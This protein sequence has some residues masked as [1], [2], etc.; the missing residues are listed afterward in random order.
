MINSS[1]LDLLSFERRKDGTVH[2]LTTEALDTILSQPQ[3][4]NIERGETELVQSRLSKVDIIWAA[5]PENLS[6][7]IRVQTVWQ[8][9]S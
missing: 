6:V 3:A 5:T 2:I 1:C 9:E 8:S 7:L 4:T